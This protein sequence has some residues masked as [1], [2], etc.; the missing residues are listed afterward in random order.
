LPDSD[1]NFTGNLVIGQ[2]NLAQSSAQQSSQM[3]RQQS[4]K[5][6]SAPAAP[7]PPTASTLTSSASASQLPT[8]KLAPI[9]ETLRSLQ[10]AAAVSQPNV[11]AASAPLSGSNSDAL[12]K[13]TLVSQIKPQSEITMPTVPTFMTSYGNLLF[14]MDQSSFVS[15]YEKQFSV[16]LKLRNSVKLN[17]PNVKGLAV[18]ARYLAVAYSGLKKEHLKGALKNVN[19][20]GIFLYG[21]DNHVICS[22]YEKTIDLAAGK[23]EGGFKALTS[24]ALTDTGALFAADR[25]QMCIFQIEISSG[26]LLRTIKTPDGHPGSL[27]LNQ[28]YLSVI[29]SLNSQLHVFDVHTLALVSSVSLKSIDQIN[30]SLN[31]ILTE[32]NLIF[33]RNSDHQ[34]ALLDASLEPRA[35]F[36]E[37]QAKLTNL[38]ILKD[39]NQSLLV[40]GGI[41]SKQQYKIFGYSI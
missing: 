22:V 26:S 34:L 9:K 8:P 31:A 18:N 17:L 38:A 3:L 5:S 21:R 27:C 12:S 39:Q 1:F 10:S 29:D 28:S 2:I 33:V 15:V 36:N 13:W 4:T 37:I 35:F 20:T 40:I 14:T 30:G 32:D 24:V 23:S 19:P 16:E 41:N 25:D 6:I 7:P 11:V